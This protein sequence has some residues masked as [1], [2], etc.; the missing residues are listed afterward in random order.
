MEVPGH[1]RLYVL[2]CF[3]RYVTVYAQQVRAL[4]LVDTL[5]KSGHL[6][7]RSEVAVIGGGIAGLTAAA[8]AAVRGVHRVAVFEKLGNTMRIQRGTEKRFIHPHIYDWPAVPPL[9]NKEAEERAGLDILDWAPGR[10][11]EVVDELD[12]Q[13][14]ALRRRHPALEVPRFECKAIEITPEGSKWAVS[15]GSNRAETFDVA[16]LAVGFGRDSADPT[17]GYWTDTNLDG[18]EAESA[19]T[20]FVSG[21]GDGGLTDLMRLCIMDFR[22]RALLEE[23]DEATREQVGDDLLKT[24]KEGFS[25]GERAKA[26][27]QVAEKVKLSLDDKLLKRKL[28]QVRLNCST[29]SDLFSGRSSI[30][31][32]LIAAYLLLDGR[33][34]LFN[35]GRIK[36]PLGKTANDK[37]LIEFEN[38]RE[39]F[40]VD[41]VILRH[42]PNSALEEGFPEI[43]KRC[44]RLDETW[45][46]AQQHEDW[47]REPLYS[48]KDFKPLDPPRLR[49]DFG[50]KAGCVVITGSKPPAGLTLEQRVEDA[51]K[52]FKSRLDSDTNHAVDT[53]PVHISAAEAFSSPASYEWTV[54]ALC[55]SA[56]AVFDVTD[57]ES[58]VML[59]LGIRASVRRGVTLTI[60]Q[61]DSSGPLLPFNLA[62]L[63][64]ITL[65]KKIEPIATA[66]E[67]GLASL[68]TQSNSYLDLPAFDAVRHLGVDYEP[69]PLANQVLVL[70][71]FDKQYD[72]LVKPLIEAAV[73]QALGSV[74]GVVT[75]L[76]S[77]SPQLVGQRL[78]AA[79]RRTQ[80]C[81]ADWTAWRPN[82]FFEIGVRL[83]VNPIDPVF[84]L[85]QDQPPG[86]MN[87]KTSPWPEKPDAS[88][89]MLT[90][91]FRP[92]GFSFPTFQRDLAGILKH[93]SPKDQ[94]PQGVLSPGRTY[95]VICEAI[96]RALEPG[97]QPLVEML[98][99][100][101]ER[102]AG[103]AVPER[104]G[105]PLLYSDVLADQARELSV[106][107]LLAA[108]HYLDRRDARGGKGLVECMR[109]QELQSTD[110]RLA[111][112]RKVGQQLSSRL[113]NASPND[114]VDAIKREIR[115]AL[116]D[117]GTGEEEERHG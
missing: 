60:S 48:S 115:A 95:Q 65:S 8:A 24:E 76:D 59:L 29:E 3:A 81:V 113:R 35:G 62:A 22:H 12:R 97:G 117:L 51:M 64:P 46:S 110:P 99:S 90:E 77:S 71:W 112:L 57:F 84:L 103:P 47:T 18:L 96:P 44:R 15:V 67:T 102:I 53:K 52:R 16:V 11:C 107:M 114:R 105:F 108:W 79:I 41:H 10:A 82:V 42:G 94:T 33:F 9:R 104:G 36:L 7:A 91:F 40:A 88:A 93:L 101:A 100:E 13:W 109:D 56:V 106:E 43:W 6:S 78:Y 116:A 68:R 1:P 72:E 70:R 21:H 37:H 69:I 83:A 34:E 45:K 25:P 74:T 4:N 89:A 87:A 39:P 50:E 63:N 31:N 66:I 27:L 14:E 38:G 26:F 61:S 32:R 86:W 73:T 20:W 17:E 54:R 5:A 49:V 2:G 58:A 30:L 75:T 55:V 85:C 92:V 111:P 23:I 19:G 98:L 80:A 28:D